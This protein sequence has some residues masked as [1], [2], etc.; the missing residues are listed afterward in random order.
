MKNRAVNFT[1]STFTRSETHSGVLTISSSVSVITIPILNYLI[2]DILASLF[3]VSDSGSVEIALGDPPDEMT[4]LLT[5]EYVNKYKTKE[6]NIISTISFHIHSH[7]PVFLRHYQ[8]IQ[9][10]LN[11]C[12]TNDPLVRCVIFSASDLYSLLNGNKSLR[13]GGRGGGGSMTLNMA[14]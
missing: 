10:E 3:S 2:Y 5:R 7:S 14:R 13:K 8:T 1:G 12:F 4:K 11:D 6:N 9:K